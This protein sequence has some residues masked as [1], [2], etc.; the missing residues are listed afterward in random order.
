MGLVTR[1]DTTRHDT[2]RHDTTRHDTTFHL[3]EG[4]ICLEMLEIPSVLASVTLREKY[5]NS[6]CYE[7]CTIYVS[8]DRIRTTFR[9]GNGLKLVLY[10]SHVWCQGHHNRNT[11]EKGSLNY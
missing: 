7:F 3:V 8:F 6:T 5:F 2:T 1:H 11:G 4:D 9:Y 10:L